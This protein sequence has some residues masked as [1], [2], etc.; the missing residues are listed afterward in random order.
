MMRTAAKILLNLEP[1]DKRHGPWKIQI[2]DKEEQISLIRSQIMDCPRPKNGVLYEMDAKVPAA[3]AAVS[4]SIKHRIECTPIADTFKVRINPE[5]LGIHL[6]MN[7]LLRTHIQNPAVCVACHQPVKHTYLR[8]DNMEGIHWSR[9]CKSPALE[10]RL[11]SIAINLGESNCAFLSFGP[12][13]TLSR[14][15]N[16]IIPIA[17]ENMHLER[18]LL[19]NT[20]KQQNFY[21][22]Q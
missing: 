15:K 4:S 2:F 6:D 19:P 18:A 16:G 1:R 14:N 17:D 13:A 3:W 11:F 12:T 7:Y 5:P 21:R 9:K 8:S 10:P 20:K 22:S